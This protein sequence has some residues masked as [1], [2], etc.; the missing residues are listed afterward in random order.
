MGGGSFV[1]F[2]EAKGFKIV[3]F[4]NFFEDNKECDIIITNPPYSLKEEFF[5]RAYE[6]GKPFAFLMPLTT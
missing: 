1:R 3:S 4:K 2:L 5:K 6:L